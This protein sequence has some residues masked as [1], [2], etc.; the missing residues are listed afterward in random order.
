MIITDDFAK[1]ISL[2]HILSIHFNYLF[3]LNITFKI[4]FTIL[5]WLISFQ[6]F[7]IKLYIADIQRNTNISFCDAYCCILMS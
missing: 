6:W 1:I 7:V 2:G 5:I 3:T 4:I